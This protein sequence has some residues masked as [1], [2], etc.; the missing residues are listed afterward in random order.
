MKSIFFDTPYVKFI[1]KSFLW[2]TSDSEEVYNHNINHRPGDLQKY[3]WVNSTV[4][5]NINNLGFRGS[6][7]DIAAPSVMFLGCSHTFGVGLPIENTWPTMIANALSLQCVNLGM[8]GASN[9]S[10][11]RY[12]YYHI[13][14]IKPKLVV[15]LSPDSSR[16]EIIEKDRRSWRLAVNTSFLKMLSLNL[17]K[18]GIIGP[19]EFKS[20]WNS[21]YTDW[22][23]SKTNTFLNKQKNILAISEIC[24]QHNI[25]L[26]TLDVMDFP[27]VDLAR[28]LLHRGRESNKNFA[29]LVLSK[30]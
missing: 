25:T 20:G 2:F 23:M 21:F 11:F 10:A 24:T 5:Y 29:Q 3:K 14:I 8:P 9:D 22:I 1:G 6:D 28:D 19:P 12:A 27:T 15:L 26:L 18:P 16:F 7:V 17:G 30:I 13:P 4:V